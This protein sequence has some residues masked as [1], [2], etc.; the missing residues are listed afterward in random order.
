MTN[1]IT[2]ELLSRLIVKLDDLTQKVNQ[3]DA[4]VTQLQNEKSNQTLTNEDVD[5]SLI[6]HVNDIKTILNGNGLYMYDNGEIPI[7]T[8]SYTKLAYI[9]CKNWDISSITS[10]NGLFCDCSNV[11][12]LNLTGWNTKHITDMSHMFYG[13]TKLEQ[14]KGLENLNVKNVESMKEMFNGCESLTKLDLSK[15]KTAKPVNVEPSFEN[16][17]NRKYVY[18]GMFHNCITLK[19]VKLGFELN[20][21]GHTELCDKKTWYN[22]YPLYII[23]LINI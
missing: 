17:S 21:Q 18:F 2:T 4:K 22:P 6:E 20:L 23:S 7:P 15:W 19:I 13:C 12:T 16:P 8:I 3:L 10:F 5:T 1:V 9:D 14:I 11:R